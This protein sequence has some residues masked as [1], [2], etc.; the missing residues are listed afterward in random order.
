MLSDQ[1]KMN[2]QFLHKEGVA[3]A[4]QSISIPR[5]LTPF[6]KDELSRVFNKLFEELAIELY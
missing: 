1:K 5:Q 3:L 6:Y 2:G 4:K